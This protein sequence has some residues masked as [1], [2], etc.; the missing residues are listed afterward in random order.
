MESQIWY[1]PVSSVAL[2]GEGSDQEQWSF[3]QF[4]LGE[5][6]PPAPALM[7]D[8]SVPPHMPLVPFKLLPRCWS[9]EGV[10]QNKFVCG[11][12][13]RNCL[14][15]QQF[16]PQTQ[17]HWFLQPEVMG[18][19]L[20]GT[21]TLGWEAWCG[22]GIPCSQDPSFYALH[23]GVGPACSASLCVYIFAPPTS[24]DVCGLFNSVVVGFPFNSF[25]D[26]SE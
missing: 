1:L 26:G 24:L 11:P 13:K 17:S 4:C 9:S 22:A 6:C 14:G 23:V 3:L 15:I 7:P 16:L 10:S 25:S 19:C 12:F 8:T 21:G 18:T 20:L 5:N 2:C